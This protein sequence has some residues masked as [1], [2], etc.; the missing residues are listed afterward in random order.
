MPRILRLINRLNLGGP[1]FNAAYLTKYLSPDFETLLV[2]GMID[3]SEASSEFI[4]RDMGL[5]PVFLRQMYRAI[6]PSRDWQA[7]RQLKKLIGDF[8]PDIVHTHAAKA[9]ALGRMAAGACGVPVVVH[10][11]HGHVFH[12]YFSSI[13]SGI[14][15]R[16]ERFLA[17]KSDAIIAISEKQKSE[18]S[19]RFRICAAE[20]IKVI[21]LGFDLRHFSQGTIEK[22]K[23]FRENY[24]VEGDEFVIA[25][26]GRLVPVKNHPMFLSAV[27]RLVPRTS[28][29]VRVFI[30]G[31]GEEHEKLEAICR[32]LSLSFCNFP[33]SPQKATVTFTSWIKNVDEVYAGSD[34]I[35][36]SSRNEGT[37]VSIIEALASGK[38]VVTTDAGGIG[39][40]FVQG[41]H[42]LIV[43][44]EQASAFSDAL[45]QVMEN[46]GLYRSATESSKELLISRFHYQRLI[47]ETK[48]LYLHL[49]RNQSR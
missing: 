37:P 14:F 21:P 34:L 38:P 8:K 27:A 7:Y 20:K 47:E 11:F 45:L 19:N 5:E 29:K 40:F 15:I 9:G 48:S 16:L 18:L 39:D 42:G 24:F 10:T 30:V 2:A 44:G 43:S 22:R 28:K 1:T 12:S 33:L 31:D 26:V 3:E 13:K 17:T 6:H 4:V 46:P 36:L 25:V 35:A 23:R 49:L 32:S 41:Q